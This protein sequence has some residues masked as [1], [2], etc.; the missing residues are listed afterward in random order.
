M[1][2]NYVVFQ[3]KVSAFSLSSLPWR[4]EIV[5]SLSSKVLGAPSGFVQDRH[6]QAQIW[7]RESPKLSSAVG[8]KGLLTILPLVQ[9]WVWYAGN[10]Q[11]R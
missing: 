11:I 2:I 10:E 4:K 5:R 8:M 3:K 1:N 7:S 9:R 6:L